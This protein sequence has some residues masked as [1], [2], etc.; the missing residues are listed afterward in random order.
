MQK[1]KLTRSERLEV[2]MTQGNI[3]RHIITFA[4][5]LLLG[6]IFQQLYNMVDAWG[7][8]NYV[9]K[10]A[11]SAVGSVGPI[12]N[13]LIGFF[14]GLA[15]G[16]GAVI[17]Q[18]YGA[19][20]EDRVRS[21]V[22]TAM[23]M[24]LLLGVLFIG[25]GIALTPAMLKL[26]NTPSDAWADAST[27]LYVYFAGILGLMVYNMGSGI[28]RAV[29]DSRRPFYFLLVCAGLNTVLDLYFVLRLH[30]GVEG[31]ALATIIAQFISAA[32]V[33]LV[34][35]RSDSCV[36][37]EFCRL[38]IHWD[39]LKRIF[40]IGFPAGLQMAVTAFSNVFVQ[41]YI[42]F[43]GTDCMAGWAAFS[44]MD[45][46]R[47]LPIQ[48]LAM[49]ATTFVAQNLGAA[50]AERAK[51]GT[52]TAVSISAL[53]TAMISLPAYIFAPS[54]TAFFNSEPGV[55]RYGALIIR[56]IIPFG[57]LS[58]INQVLA[59]ALR[60]AGNSR[61]PMI[62]ILSSFVAVRQVYLFIMSRL[63]NQVVPI[64]LSYPA[65]WIICAILMLAYYRRVGLSLRT[66]SSE[67]KGHAR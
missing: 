55:I 39:I 56:W 49:S 62:I 10:A 59:G 27:Y 18:L 25:I 61:A 40:M 44:K 66:A 53:C 52:W 7:V 17:S 6:N 48:S 24:T 33:V 3:S 26:M 38:K 19:K 37:L 54:V 14:S 11:F 63:C 1:A 36:K 58:C 4:L 16:A 21:S 8:G 23:L 9:S 22:H 65:G 45:Q 64:V 30:M 28:L 42:N 51:R 31:V 57:M 29:G 5:P 46:F 67:R 12:S 43:F 35:L 47:M 60:G 41:S 34:L 50:Q 20:D 13:T 15:T 2:D 32:L